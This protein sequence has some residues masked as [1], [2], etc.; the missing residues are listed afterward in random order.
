MKKFL[1]ETT[2]WHILVVLFS[3]GFIL[4]VADGLLS[5]GQIVHTLVPM[6]VGLGISVVSVLILW[7]SSEFYKD[8]ENGN[9]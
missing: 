9:G 2:R 8:K 6:W 7:L 1:K 5:T 4:F 3:V